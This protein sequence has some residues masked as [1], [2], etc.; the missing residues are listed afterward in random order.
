V[1]LKIL[2]QESPDSEL[3]LKRYEGLK[4]QGPKLEFGKLW[5]LIC[6]ISGALVKRICILVEVE[7]CMCRIGGARANLQ[8][9]SEI[10]GPRCKFCKRL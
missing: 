1:I 8:I 9:D 3:Q 4:F 5:G 6:K 10:Q 2:A 7:G